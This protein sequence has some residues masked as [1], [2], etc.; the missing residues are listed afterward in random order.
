MFA[1]S[2]GLDMPFQPHAGGALEALRDIMDGKFQWAMVN[3]ASAAPLIREGKLR[4]LAVSGGQRVPAFPEVP[5][6]DESGFQGLFSNAWQAL[7]A[8]GG[9]SRDIIDKLHRSVV[10][11]VGLPS[12]RDEFEKRNIIAVTSQ[13]PQAFAAELRDDI[14]R[15]ER[16]VSESGI[17][18]E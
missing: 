1:K 7:F 14:A 16:V 2:A 5:T 13:S 12:V 10:A 6:V 4:A 8:P 15:K 17:V 11:V 9:T 3:A 18:I